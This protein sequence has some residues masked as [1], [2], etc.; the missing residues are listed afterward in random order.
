MDI[1]VVVWKEVWVVPSEMVTPEF[2]AAVDKLNNAE[3]WEPIW[4]EAEHEAINR[5]RF[6]DRLWCL[7]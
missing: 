1:K 5:V 2:R 7:S 6:S 3:S 4:T